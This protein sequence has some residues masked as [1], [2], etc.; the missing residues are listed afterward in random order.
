MNCSQGF[1]FRSYVTSYVKCPCSLPTDGTFVSIASLRDEGGCCCCRFLL[2]VSLSHSCCPEASVT[3]PF[4]LFHTSVLFLHSR[5]AFHGHSHFC[6]VRP[7][8]LRLR[9]NFCSNSVIY[10]G[11]M[12]PVSG[13]KGPLFNGTSCCGN[14]RLIFGALFFPCTFTLK[15]PS[16]PGIILLLL[17]AYF[18][19]HTAAS[20]ELISEIF[21]AEWI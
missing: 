12:R 20:A 15:F 3:T 8:T 16:L 10:I 18:V 1:H 6:E 19:A 17:W 5:L 2:D 13:F 7:S 4:L 21:V 11:H 9:L 14:L